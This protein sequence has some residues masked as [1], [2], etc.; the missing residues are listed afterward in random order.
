MSLCITGGGGGGCLTIFWTLLFNPHPWTGGLDRCCLVPA[1]SH[2]SREWDLTEWRREW[3][4]PQH[5]QCSQ[6]SPSHPKQLLTT[7]RGQCMV[8]CHVSVT[9]TWV[10]CPMTCAVLFPPAKNINESGRSLEVATF[11][12]CSVQMLKMKSTVLSRTILNCTTD[13]AAWWELIFHFMFQQQ[14]VSMSQLRFLEQF[15]FLASISL[16]IW[17]I[18]SQIWFQVKIIWILCLLW[19]ELFFLRIYIIKPNTKSD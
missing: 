12:D 10:T 1:V 2:I 5:T 6:Y 18:V 19:A 15:H 11:V 17:V 7:V 13:P 3:C 14:Q 16:I 8:T 9:M 4:A